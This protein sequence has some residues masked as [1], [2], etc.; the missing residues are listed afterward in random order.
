VRAVGRM[1]N[2]DE[3]IGI[4]TAQLW[5]TISPL[6]V[7]EG[8]ANNGFVVS[9]VTPGKRCGAGRQIRRRRFLPDSLQFCSVR[10][11]VTAT[12]LL[13][14]LIHVVCTILIFINARF[15]VPC[16]YFESNWFPFVKLGATWVL[17]LILLQPSAVCR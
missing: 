6:N 11:V 9:S 4:S 2:A 15:F 3:P 13:G 10:A 14:S 12:F 17:F 5:L 7:L 16:P 1:P 8:S